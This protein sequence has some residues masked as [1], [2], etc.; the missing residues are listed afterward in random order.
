MSTTEEQLK[1]IYAA[2]GSRYG[3]TDVLADFTPHADLKVSWTRSYRIAAFHVS[4]YLMNAPESVNRDIA[5][6]IFASIV[7][8]ESDYGSEAKRW[9]TSEEF[10][11]TN[12]E[13]FLGRKKFIDTE[14]GQDEDALGFLRE[15]ADRGVFSEDDIKDIQVY[16]KKTSEEDGHSFASALMKVIVLDGEEINHDERNI[17]VVLTQKLEELLDGRRAFA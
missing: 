8:L 3:Y 13:T 5:K 12:R 14:R 9:L 7:G 15:L 17:P 6:K 16:H 1:N 10:L 11:G 2:E 4:D